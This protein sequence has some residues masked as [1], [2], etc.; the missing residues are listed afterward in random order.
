MV[1]GLYLVFLNTG[2]PRTILFVV[3]RSCLNENSDIVD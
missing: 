2:Q 1:I 3:G